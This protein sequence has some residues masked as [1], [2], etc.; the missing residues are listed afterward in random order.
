MGRRPPAKGLS[1]VLEPQ[2]HPQENSAVSV[3]RSSSGAVVT[4]TGQID[5]DA[6]G[7]LRAEAE[8]LLAESGPVALDW[9]AAEHASAGAVQ[10]LLALEA[11]LKARGRPLSVVHDQAEIRSMLEL[12]GLNGHFPIAEEPA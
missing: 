5:L 9:R 11:A 4:L 2:D 6:A 7:R 1:G 3:T 12:A 8:K 10:V